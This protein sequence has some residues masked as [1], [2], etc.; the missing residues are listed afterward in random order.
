MSSLEALFRQ[1]QQWAEALGENF[2]LPLF[3]FGPKYKKR[4]RETLVLINFLNGIAKLATWKSR[5]NQMLG[6]GWT[7]VVKCFKGLIATRVKIE[8]AFYSLT[9][10]LEA[11]TSQWGIRQVLCSTEEDGSLIL[12]F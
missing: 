6:I 12:H 11:F 5:K 7:D 4:N 10:N 2:S 1:L 8:H 9:S 3:V